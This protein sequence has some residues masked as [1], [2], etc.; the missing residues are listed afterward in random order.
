[1]PP[2]GAEWFVSP[3]GQP[4]GDGSVA[5]PWD[6]RTAW[7]APSQVQPGDRVTLLPGDYITGFACML[8][9]DPVAPVMVSTT[10]GGR[11]RIRRGVTAQGGFVRF[12][13]L[14]AW[15]HWNTRQT[16]TPGSGGTPG[17]RSGS[18]FQFHGP[19]MA[20][21]N[22]IS[23]NSAGA[24]IG[25]W[26]GAIDGLAYGNI[27]YNTGWVAPDRGHGHAIYSNGKPGQKMLDNLF[28]NSFDI[29][30]QVFEGLP[31]QDIEVVGNIGFQDQQQNYWY[32]NFNAASDG[33]KFN[34]N[35][36]FRATRAGFRSMADWTAFVGA[37]NNP[38]SGLSV[39]MLRN[40][41][42]GLSHNSRAGAA[43]VLGWSSGSVA[44][45]RIVSGSAREFAVWLQAGSG[46]Y[47]S[48]DRNAYYY[49]GGDP[50]PF[51]DSPAPGSWNGLD[52]AA[53]QGLGRDPNG[54]YVDTLPGGQWVSVRPN[55]YEAG[56]AH[57]AVYDWD[58]AGSAPLDL[59]AVLAMGDP[60]RVHNA[61]DVFGPPVAQG[62]YDGSPVVV[63]VGGVAVPIPIG[64]NGGRGSFPDAAPDF[65]A[66]LVRKA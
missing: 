49:T 37:M 7:N 57:A 1:M 15:E 60:Y 53:W 11:C 9:G 51:R 66:Y 25:L 27:I 43:M 61:Y 3:N 36:A 38:S 52:W 17:G 47:P 29:G 28:F 24:G 45:N 26:T 23:H 54:S 4:T 59:S 13:N 8:A 39:E 35:L 19:G 10:P 55:V 14:E 34:D 65:S 44:D 63:P 18:G 22:C 50:R 32:G 48:F 58:R 5:S 64:G 12:V 30:L 6:I 42:V 40:T 41:L 21:I 46:M 62:V 56:R 31:M 2:T 33:L 16:T 20:A